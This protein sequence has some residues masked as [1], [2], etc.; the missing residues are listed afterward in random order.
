[1]RRSFFAKLISQ[2]PMPE[3]YVRA[4]QAKKINGLGLFMYGVL[5]TGSTNKNYTIQ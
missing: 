4:V 1:M 2:L 5:L 3:I